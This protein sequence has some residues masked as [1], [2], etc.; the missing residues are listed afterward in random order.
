MCILDGYVLCW[1]DTDRDMYVYE[2][3]WRSGTAIFYD[4]EMDNSRKVSDQHYLRYIVV[5]M[6]ST[7]SN[8]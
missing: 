3:P 5:E 1:K 2:P 8:E 4:H 6:N 7:Q